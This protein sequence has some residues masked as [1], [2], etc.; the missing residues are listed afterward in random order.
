M[1]PFLKL[2][3]SSNLSTAHGLAELYPW[4]F[5]VA[6]PLLEKVRAMKKPQRRD[7]LLRPETK[8]QTYSGLVGLSKFSRIGTDNPAQGMRALVIDYDMKCSL[9]TALSFI[10]QLPEEHRPNFL[11]VSI[12]KKVRLV[13]MFERELLC[14][15]NAHCAALL[16]T[17]IEKL[18][19]ENL[20]PGFDEA[21]VKPSEFWTNG[22]EW[23]T[24]RAHP[25]SW[26]L[27]FGIACDASKKLPLFSTAEVPMEKLA[28]EVAK[29]YPSRWQGEFAVDN[30]GVRFW[31]EHADCPT[32]CQV[33]PDGM[34]C[35]T[36]KQPFVT[37]AEIFGRAW[38]DEQRA[39]NLG[40][41]A[42]NLYFDGRNY[43]E[44]AGGRWVNIGRTDAM[45]ALKD[46]G[47]SD[48]APRGAPI[49]D[50]ERVLRH[51][52]QDNRIDG[53]A[54]LINYRPG[55]V[56]LD[57]QRILNVS[58]ARA[59]EPVQGTG[60]PE[61]DFPWIWYF[62]NGHF[63]RPEGQPLHYFLATL[64]R[65]YRSIR[66]YEPKMGQAL[67]VCG[68]RSNGKTLLCLRIVAPLLG[69]RVANPYSYFVGDTSFNDELFSATLLAI[70]D[71][72][73]PRSE[74]AR[75]SLIA[76]IKAHVVN[77]THTYHP[78]FCS[79]VTVYWTGRIF[80]TLND[81]AMSVGLLP[82]VNSNTQDK[83]MFFASKEY[84]GVWDDNAVV[85]ARIAAELPKFA[86]WLDKV[87]VPPDFVLAPGR[88]GV[89]SYFDP[90]ILDLSRQQNFA[91]NLLELLR[92][93]ISTDACWSEETNAQG[94]WLGTPTDL[95]AAMSG[96]DC[97]DSIVRAWDVNRIAKSLMTLDR[98]EASGVEL[99]SGTAGQRFFR[100]TKS[101]IMTA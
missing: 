29:R 55:I 71:E 27:I 7:W 34:L 41:A 75:Q 46:K 24:L 82:E 40:Q 91:F 43:W 48:K 92:S 69:N 68:P 87:Y 80:I 67:F 8:W 1:A 96:N 86:W 32:G 53:A 47:L 94:V 35:F 28:E 17:F 44:L 61:T 2:V 16:K 84:D 99:V 9:E 60:K 20:L 42:E 56:Q 12:G 73:S 39:L 11:E 98:A 25:L 89:K 97:L 95:L 13:W 85:E 88:V 90:V 57:G 30:L 38:V 81:D 5:A 79:K 59:L 10:N 50:A 22:G 21:S 23:F 70:N 66:Y 45:L 14:A 54:P 64:Q 78:K 31:D 74:A 49:S 36:G 77:P 52:Q 93:W 4:E 63:A 18:K 100:L 15:G 37:W 101:K 72:E 76:K 62:M 6:P 26:T 65:G 3:S 58:T 19:L 51:I 33:K 83:M